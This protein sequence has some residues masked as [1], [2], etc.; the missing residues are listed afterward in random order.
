MLGDNPMCPKR[1]R[2]RVRSLSPLGAAQEFGGGGFDLIAEALGDL[3]GLHFAGGGIAADAGG[4]DAALSGDAAIG[5][6]KADEMADDLAAHFFDEQLTLKLL[7]EAQR[8]HVVAGGMHAGPADAF[9]ADGG[10]IDDGEAKAA[11]EGVLHPFHVAEEVR[12]M[13]DAGHV[14]IGELDA[15]GAGEAVGHGGT[16]DPQTG[17]RR[18]WRSRRQGDDLM[19]FLVVRLRGKLFDELKSMREGDAAGLALRMGEQPV[20]VA[21]A[22]SEAG[23]VFR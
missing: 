17:D 16:S 13:H 15:F 12:K 7:L 18:N 9:F 10:R 11:E 2:A 21:A 5:F 19:H 6:P 1:G 4:G 20:V 22:A 8:A 3:D 14:G 23:E